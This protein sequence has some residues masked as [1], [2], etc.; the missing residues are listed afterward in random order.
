MEIKQIPLASVFP[1][2]M[3]PRKTFN[4]EELQEL[5]DN[6]GKQGLLQPIT[7]RPAADGKYEIICGERRYRAMCILHGRNAEVQ[8]ISAIV[9]E[10]DDDEAFDAMITENLQRKDVDPMEEAYAFSQLIGKGNTAE[11]IA[12][13]FGKSV[14][15][16]QDRVKLNGLI[17]ELMLAIKENKMSISAAMIIAKLD[18]AQQHRY[19]DSYTKNGSFDKASAESFTKMLFMSIQ[20]A[21][22]YKSG[23]K[24][25]RGFEGGCNRKCSKCS[26]NTANQGCLFW[27]MKSDDTVGR[28]TDREMFQKK[29]VAF[30]LSIVEKYKDELVKLG[31]PLEAGKMVVID[32]NDYCSDNTKKL[33]TATY[34]AIR[35]AGY[36]VVTGKE[37][38]EGR[39]Y[40]NDERLERKKEQHK[41]FRCLELF[42]YDDVKPTE[43]WMYFKG[44]SGD[45]AD[46]AAKPA[47]ETSLSAQAMQLMQQRE[48]AKEIAIENITKDN[49]EMATNL[50]IALRKGE[51]SDGEQLALDLIIFTLCGRKMQER[52]GHKG[53]G[54]PSDR[55]YIEIVKQNQADRAMW[56]R[57]FIRETISSADIMYNK[58]YQHVADMVLGEW[59]PKEHQEMT[60][61]HAEK[62]DKKLRSIDAKLQEIGYGPDG[63]LL[64]KPVPEKK[65]SSG[66][67]TIWEAMKQYDDLKKKH[68]DVIILIRFG[69][70]Y[71]AYD[72]DAQKVSEVLGVTLT[73]IAF[74]NDKSRTIAIAGFPLQ[75]LDTYLPKLIKA[76]HKVAICNEKDKVKAIKK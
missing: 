70:F 51:L 22:W 72:D 67:S 74:K 12:L 6:I 52:Y 27:E 5:A 64:E 75:A 66:Q 28:C 63:K 32:S 35:A 14:R 11:E 25:D 60:L 29:Q 65:A 10:M 56:I 23:N 46:G 42:G 69:D 9:R 50:G 62:L 57:D 21:P 18:E 47:A 49:R 39:C 33:K 68:P 73:K 58:I 36:E 59:K 3:N 8:S 76:G 17:P 54:N 71:Q 30:I 40:Y 1:S 55:K 37:I 7:V 24:A 43:N 15:F 20:N 61:G 26:L 48:R 41:V 31:S 53:C 38:F 44:G 13:R 2:P 16:V 34:E 45:D 4:E 19:H